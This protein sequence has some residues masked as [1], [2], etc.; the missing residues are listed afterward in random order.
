MYPL[1]K[2]PTWFLEKVAENLFDFIDQL[3]GVSNL[4]KADTKITATNFE[5]MAEPSIVECFMAFADPRK[6]VRNFA[7]RLCQ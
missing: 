7:S 2:N 3:Q 4:S 1:N 6:I 5:L